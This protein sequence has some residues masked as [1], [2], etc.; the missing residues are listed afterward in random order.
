MVRE[1]FKKPKKKDSFKKQK[2]KQLF[3]QLM[4]AFSRINLALLL[5]HM[6]PCNYNVPKIEF[7]FD[8]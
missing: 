6:A 2:K 4:D 5:Q 7:R 3:G 1:M 8:V